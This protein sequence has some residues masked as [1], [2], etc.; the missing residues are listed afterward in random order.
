MSQEAISSEVASLPSSGPSASAADDRPSKAATAKRERLGINMR[1]LPLFGDG[2]AGDAIEVVNAFHSAIPEQLR[3]RR[4]N[5]PRLVGCAALQ[6]SGAAVPAPGDTEAGQRFRQHWLLEGG[7]CPAFATIGRDIHLGDLAI[8]RPGEARN[9][10]EA[11]SLH[12]QAGR[13][14]RNHRLAFHR[15]DELQ[16]LTVRQRDRIFGGLVLGHRRPF[17]DFQPPQP[18]DV[19]IAFVPWKQQPDGVAVRWPNSL[20]VL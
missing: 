11:Y 7:W 5:I 13:G 9:L 4:L 19:H 16:R 10:I 15:E 14:M 6:N 1:Q 3:T 18:F 12:R 2:P 20:A 8:A 17:G